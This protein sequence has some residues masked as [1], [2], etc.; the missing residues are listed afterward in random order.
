MQVWNVLHGACWKY[1][2]QKIVKNSPSWHHR[3]TLSGYIFTTKARIDNRKK[4][5]KQ[6]C[7][8]HM[9]SQYGELWSTSGW[10]R[11]VSF[12]HPSKFQG[13]HILASSLLQRR[14]STETNQTL[15]SVWPSPWMVHYI[16]IFGGSCR[17][18][19]FCQVQNLPCV[20]SLALSYIC[21]I[22]AR[23]SSSGR[24]PNFAAWYKEC[25]TEISQ[26]VP[27]IFGWVAITL[28]SAH[29]LLVFI[30]CC[31]FLLIDEYVHLSCWF[32]AKWPLF[33]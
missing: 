5:V 13:F 15:H 31:T 6:Q 28:A 19:E 20:P 32:T 12:G 21:I 10:D 1:R 25:I 27:P 18:T 30:L 22:T 8:S 14:R 16:Y 3:T 4:L 33:S 9:S 23:H 17:V 7:L 26:S 11:Y 29:I 2:M 24:P